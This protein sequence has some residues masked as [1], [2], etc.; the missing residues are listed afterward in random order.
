MKAF[1]KVNSLTYYLAAMAAVLLLAVPA[2]AQ[3]L[4]WTEK[5]PVNIPV[6]RDDHM[7]AFDSLRGRIVMI[8]GDNA[9][10]GTYI[11][12]GE[13]WYD[14]GVLSPVVR[15]EAVMVYD[16]RRDRMVMFSGWDYVILNPLTWEFD[17]EEWI[18]LNYEEDGPD[19]RTDY[20]ACF[21]EN[22]GITILYGGESVEGATWGYN[23][24]SWFILVDEENSPGIRW[25]HQMV[26]D[27][28][29]QRTVMYGGIV[30]GFFS[31][32]VWEFDGSQWIEVTPEDGAAAPVARRD[33][34]MTFDSRLGKVIMFGGRDNDP[35]G[36]NDLWM[37]DEN[38]WTPLAT[39]NAPSVRHEHAGVY[40]YWRNEFLIFGGSSGNSIDNRFKTDT[41]VLTH[42]DTRIEHEPVTDTFLA[43]EDIIISADV[44]FEG[45]ENVDV[46]IF[47]RTT[48]A[49]D[50]GSAPMFDMGDGNWSG[51]IIGQFV[52]APGVD[53]YIGVTDLDTG[54]YKLWKNRIYPQQITV[55]NP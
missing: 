41:W 16:S 38:G 54:D 20:A 17:G 27:P 48:G 47:F 39:N 43:G 10:Q 50:F 8:G 33:H 34:V 1:F 29:R 32:E 25:G 44:E 6:G 19:P 40:D 52:V 9:D 11:W 14:I 55:V 18:N 7:M 24:D 30:N 5:Q 4:T 23:G 2:T 51:V 28:V 53:Y 37:W 26:Y 49:E 3:E 12:D 35:V 13:N 36:F 45:I 46:R 22:L 31:N 21:D 42:D 15:R